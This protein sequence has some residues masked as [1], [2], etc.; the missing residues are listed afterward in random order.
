MKLQAK[1]DLDSKKESLAMGGNRCPDYCGQ[2]VDMRELASDVKVE[3]RWRRRLN[4][5]AE[6]SSLLKE[7]LTSLF[8]LSGCSW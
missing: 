4:N 1:A 6:H 5:E 3:R 8:L 7:K 2:M